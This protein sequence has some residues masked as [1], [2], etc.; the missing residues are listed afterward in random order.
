MLITTLTS[1]LLKQILQHNIWISK[2][3]LLS[4][5]SGRPEFTVIVIQTDKFNDKCVSQ[6]DITVITFPLEL[7]FMALYKLT[8]LESLVRLFF[9][10]IE[11]SPQC[12]IVGKIH[13]RNKNRVHLNIW[14]DYSTTKSSWRISLIIA[15]YT[16]FPRRHK[17]NFFPRIFHT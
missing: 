2:S 4:Y 1:T 16:I 15:P 5:H 12:F 10:L 13:H 11:P 8:N 9:E 17:W 6:D 3:I 7:S 14:C